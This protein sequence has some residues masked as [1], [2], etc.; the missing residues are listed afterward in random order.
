MPRLETVAVEQR[1]AK[2]LDWLAPRHPD[3]VRP[4]ISTAGDRSR[5]AAS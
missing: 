2:L 5:A 3:F 1:E 4:A